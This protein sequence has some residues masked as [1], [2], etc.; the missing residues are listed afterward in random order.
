[1]GTMLRFGVL[2]ALW[3]CAGTA[4]AKVD[5]ARDIEPLLAKRCLV[6]H[7]AGQ[8]MSGLRLD[9]REAALKGGASGVDIVPG[10]S[11]ESRLVRLVSGMEKKV[12]P[13]VGTRLT[14]EEIGFLR[15][16]IDQGLDWPVRNSTHWSFQKVRRPAV[17]AV[18]NRGWPR[19]PIDNFIVAR[20][21][22]EGIAPSPEASRLTLLRRL[23]L[24]L[25]G[26]PPT[27][28]EE[29]AFLEDNRLDAYERQV[30]RLLDSP[31]YGERWARYWLDLAR[32]ADS[33]GYEKDRVRP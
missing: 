12:M 31:H 14:T 15:A 25:T 6:C 13:P 33:D 7:G 1:M 3:V 5:F 24:D 19:N 29:R 20:I 21:E 18:R 16:W 9:S 32:Y 4:Q 2:L 30:D 10:K 27:P 23:S 28:E 26:L 17:P 11:K 8:Q 22:S